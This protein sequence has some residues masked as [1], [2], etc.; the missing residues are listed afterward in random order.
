LRQE[1]LPASR[2][3]RPGAAWLYVL[4]ILVIGAAAARALV[5]AHGDRMHGATGRAEWIWYTNRIPRPA[6][7]RFFATRAFVLP[8]K[9]GRALVKLF[10]DR[11]HVLWVNGQRAGAGTQRTGDPLALYDVAALL[12]EGENRLTIEAA[13]PTG[14]GGILFSADIQSFGRDALVSDGD[15]RVDPS[16][17]AIAGPGRYRPAVWGPPPQFPWGYP[18]MPRPEEVERKLGGAR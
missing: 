13:S 9:P 17:D 1:T 15:W 14:I 11:E 7:I 3:A 12:R 16:R 2:P 6:P 10:A 4:A 8:E 18:R 5:R